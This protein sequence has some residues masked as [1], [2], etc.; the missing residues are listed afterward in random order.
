M[1]KEFES[2]R[3]FLEGSVN[4]HKRDLKE[5]NLKDFIDVY[6]AEVRKTTDEKSPFYGTMAERQLVAT[7]LD[8]FLAGSDSS[9]ATLSWTMV[10]LCK[11]PEVQKKLQKEI[12]TV[13]GNTRQVSVADRPNMPYA[14]ALVDEILRHSS[15]VADGVQHRAMA[16][17][18]FHGYRIPKDA[19][20][21]PNLFFIHRDNKIWGDGDAF[22]PERFLT[23]DGK[24]YVKSENLQPFQVGRRVCVGETLARDNIFLYLTNIFQ[25][26]DVKFD[27][28][29][30]EPS[31]ET[32]PG[33]FRAP[34]PY[35]VIMKERLSSK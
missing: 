16:E 29:G 12:E 14:L 21:Q 2:F 34:E 11:F 24:K 1:R 31:L 18:E 22:R 30:K 4:Q 13:T 25:K 28:K 20:V 23:K 8:L 6:L 33:F 15:L 5:E 17:R 10:Y 27:P 7:M 35:T 3:D 32:I 19:W 9:A 26:F